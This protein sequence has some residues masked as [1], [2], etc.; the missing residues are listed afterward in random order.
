MK[1]FIAVGALFC[2]CAGG[3]ILAAEP[4][5]KNLQGNWV[6]DVD[7]MTV[8]FSFKDKT[9]EI[10][11]EKDGSKLTIDSDFQ[12]GRDSIVFGRVVDSK[13]E[14]INS[15]SEKG[16][17]FSLGVSVEGDKLTIKELKGT[18]VNDGAKALI[19]GDYKK[20]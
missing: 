18:R 7:G 13:Q 5:A 4:T 6:R 10:K 19:E 8:A 2:L 12:T 16:D 11:L 20:K 14:G 17:L 15:E 1:S 3:V 9:L